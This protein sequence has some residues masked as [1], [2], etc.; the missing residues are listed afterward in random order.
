MTDEGTPMIPPPTGGVPAYI[1]A[2]LRAADGE[3]V[4]RMDM[5]PYMALPE[6]I[7]HPNT[8]SYDQWVAEIPAREMPDYDGPAYNA[9]VVYRLAEHST[10]TAVY[11]ADV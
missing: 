8:Q 1:H 11:Q 4:A 6:W 3:I 7:S 10:R 2:E 5:S 9:F